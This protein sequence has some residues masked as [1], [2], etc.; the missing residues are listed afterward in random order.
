MQLTKFY[1]KQIIQEEISNILFEQE[2]ASKVTAA[3]ACPPGTKALKGARAGQWFCVI[4]PA[5]GTAPRQVPSRKAWA[6]HRG[7]QK[8]TKTDKERMAALKKLQTKG[9]PTST[10]RKSKK[11]KSRR[12]TSGKCGPRPPL[13]RGWKKLPA[14]H[15]ER[16]TYRT[17]FR[18][19]YRGGPPP[20]GVAAKKPAAP[21]KSSTPTGPKKAD[22]K[23]KPTVKGPATVN[24]KEIQRLV[25]RYYA[26]RDP[27]KRQEILASLRTQSKNA[28]G[29]ADKQTASKALQAIK[30]LK[31]KRIPGQNPKK[32]QAPDSGNPI[33]G[34]KVPNLGGNIASQREYKRL[35]SLPPE[36]RKK[37]AKILRRRIERLGPQKYG[38]S[39]KYKAWEEFVKKYDPQ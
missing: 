30:N 39:D 36:R 37:R 13:R 9:K 6:D 24:P 23:T 20:K 21:A 35:A 26:E 15:P 12:R 17:W 7:K 8:E 3:N 10:K 29:E 19:K 1:L 33:G 34:I 11:S 14:K 5:D 18:C 31:K 16:A 32:S 25:D 22:P 4:T 27:K 2:K 38:G 28:S